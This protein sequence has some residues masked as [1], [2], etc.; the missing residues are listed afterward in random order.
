[1]CGFAGYIEEKPSFSREKALFQ[2]SKMSTKIISRGPDSYGHW[3]DE[4]KSIA[5]THRRLAILDL[6]EAGHQP[7]ISKSKR[8]VISYNG[9]IYNH[10]D[11][12][13]ELKTNSWNGN[14][15]TETLLACIEEFGLDLA[16]QKLNG[17]FSFALWDKKK[18]E[19]SLVRDRI[20]EKPLYYGWQKNCFLFGSDI[21]A[22]KE[23]ENFEA[24]IDEDSLFSYIR[25]SYIPSPF[26]IYKNIYK[27][28]P[29]T[30]LTLSK[31]SNRFISGF[32]PNSRKYW[33]LENTIKE[34]ISEPFEGN[35]NEAV[36]ELDKYLKTTVKQQM[37]SDV[38]LGVFLSG[39]VDSSVITALMQSQS[40]LP[41]NTFTI[42][43][44]NEIYNEAKEAKEIA[45]YF[46]TNHE[47]LYVSSKEAIDVIPDLQDI[48]SEPFAD[49]SQIPT[50]LVSK[51]AKQ[52]VSVSLSGDGGD[53]LFGGYNRHTFVEKYWPFIDR[54]PKY[55]RKKVIDII[56]LSLQ[57]EKS[58]II[59]KILSFLAFKTRVN[60]PKDKMRKI[61]DILMENSLD[62]LYFKLTSVCNNPNEILLNNKK[63]LKI[64]NDNIDELQFPSHGHNIMFRD[65]LSYLPD[66]ILVKLDRAAMAVSLETRAPFLDHRIIQFA[67]SLN[68]KL[69]IRNGE[70]KWI[71]KRILQKYLPI[72][73]IEKPKMGFGVP[74]DFWLRGELKNWANDLL[75][76]SRL[77][78]Q[79]YFNSAKVKEMF[80]EHISGK[81][82]WHHQLWTILM[83]QSWLDK[84]K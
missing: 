53:E 27:L 51:L 49:S 19:L 36:N 83:F 29:G 8:Y 13:R 21:A 46:G 33:T 3:I 44:E 50:F 10:L 63:N 69:K 20:G 47:E 61:S 73:L 71:L 59:S 22:L 17:M 39:G 70:G 16:L 4:E 23:N 6:T 48:Y 5:L 62:D 26:S 18:E 7:F 1:M 52:S 54:C 24:N 82:N 31:K 60:F 64:K 11:L 35:E 66:D 37:I 12:R 56:H 58:V 78:S 2:L 15:D 75:D 79:G 55:L 38:P 65:T 76:E 68:P 32:I 9:E 25:L 34:G 84:N 45:N 72:E 41:I 42:G 43:F 81:K 77:R 67:W 74:I 40:S 80:T 30:I 28:K 57:D 14:S